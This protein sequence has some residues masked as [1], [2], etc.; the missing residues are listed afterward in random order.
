MT[1]ANADIEIEKNKKQH[2][3]LGMLLHEIKTPL[4]VIKFGAAS[5]KSSNTDKAKT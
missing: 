2:V 3:F 1:K 5:L 4:S